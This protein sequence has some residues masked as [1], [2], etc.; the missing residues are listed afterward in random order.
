MPPAPVPERAPRQDNR[1]NALLDAAA[2]QFAERGFHATSTRELAAAVGMLPGSIY[3]HFPSKSDLL[4]AVYDEGVRRIETAV[5]QAVDGVEAPWARV[6]A[7]CTAH[8][9]ALLD[10]SAYARVVVR[11]Q[12]EDA[13]ESDAELIALRD[14]Y[15]ALFAGLI[16]DL[17]LPDAEASRAL[18]LLLLGALNWVQHWYR[19]GRDAPHVIVHRFMGLLARGKTP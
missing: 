19:P 9:E 5:A 7:A 14:R 3:Y 2:N 12:P 15:E 4:V 6:E 10:G 18:R 17:D 16:D 1:R 11:V 8:L 13:G